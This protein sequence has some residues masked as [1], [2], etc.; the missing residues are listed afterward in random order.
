MGGVPFS[1]FFHT[2]VLQVLSFC[3]W[4]M[5]LWNCRII[6]IWIGWIFIL[7]WNYPLRCNCEARLGSIVHFVGL[8]WS[9]ALKVLI[10]VDKLPIIL[11]DIRGCTQICI[12]F[13]ETNV[14]SLEA[15]LR[16]KRSRLIFVWAQ[17]YLRYPSSGSGNELEFGIYISWFE[18]FRETR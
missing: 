5:Y 7:W 18:Y 1:Q 2:Q 6:S 8:G 11:L 14:L 17:V 10:Y 13:Q 4:F 3:R 9:S 15:N 12:T 16:M